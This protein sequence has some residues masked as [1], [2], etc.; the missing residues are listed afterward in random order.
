M[1]KG[2]TPNKPKPFDPDS[3]DWDNLDDDTLL[4]ESED[5]L[6]QDSESLEELEEEENYKDDTYGNGVEG[7]YNWDEWN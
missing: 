1:P 7:I 4:D 2:Q 6:D 5:V 3:I